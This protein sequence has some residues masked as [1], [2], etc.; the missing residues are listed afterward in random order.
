MRLLLGTIV[1]VLRLLLVLLELGVLMG[2]GFSAS[3]SWSQT[4]LDRTDDG[5]AHLWLVAMG[6]LLLPVVLWSGDQMA[7]LCDSRVCV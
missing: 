6:F 3:K 5:V 2:C 7:E 1:V 4:F